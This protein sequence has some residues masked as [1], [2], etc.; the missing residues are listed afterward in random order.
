MWTGLKSVD[1]FLSVQ[2]S[3]RWKSYTRSLRKVIS[4]RSSTS[5]MI[6]VIIHVWRR[7]CVGWVTWQSWIL[8]VRGFWE[9]A[10][11]S[12][13]QLRPHTSKAAGEKWCAMRT[14][15]VTH[16]HQHSALVSLMLRDEGKLSHS[17]DLQTGRL[18]VV[19]GLRD[20]VT[21]IVPDVPGP[22]LTDVQGALLQADTPPSG[23]AH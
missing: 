15:K 22:G 4:Q 14:W 16:I 2:L 23:L 5:F 13:L 21:G 11:I 20:D 9:T 19:A 8:R 18:G 6:W 12:A 7:N 17:H 10:Y 1:F 3:T